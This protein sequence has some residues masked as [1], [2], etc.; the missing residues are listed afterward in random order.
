MLKIAKKL[1]DSSETVDA[2]IRSP[3]F[4][5]GALQSRKEGKIACHYMKTQ[6]CVKL[7]KPTEILFFFLSE[8]LCGYVLK[9]KKSYAESL[10]IKGQCLC[11]E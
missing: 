2:A 9:K 8:Y 5:T 6:A 3:S 10:T 4:K 1:N 11:S 7:K